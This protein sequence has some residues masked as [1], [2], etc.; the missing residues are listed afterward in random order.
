MTTETKKTAL[1]LFYEANGTDKNA[2]SAKTMSEFVKLSKS[3]TIADEADLEMYKE[4]CTELGLTPSKNFKGFVTEDIKVADKE[5]KEKKT[6]RLL[7]GISWVAGKSTNKYVGSV[8]PS[9]VGEDR[10]K[11][12]R[13]LHVQGVKI[14]NAVDSL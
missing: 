13:A 5:T 8:S 1:E 3:E 12:L 9:I 11:A 6:T 4:I 7:A 2:W 10:S 14:L